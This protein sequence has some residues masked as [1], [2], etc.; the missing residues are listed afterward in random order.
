VRRVLDEPSFTRAARR[1][2]T[3]VLATPAPSDIVP[4]LEKLAAASR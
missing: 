2:R 3:E 1:L 4:L